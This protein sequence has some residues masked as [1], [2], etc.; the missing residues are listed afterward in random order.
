[1]TSEG[2]A[3]EIAQNSGAIRIHATDPDRDTITMLDEQLAKLLKGD[4]VVPY[5]RSTNPEPPPIRTR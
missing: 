2:D 1:M 4:P 5:N 3:I